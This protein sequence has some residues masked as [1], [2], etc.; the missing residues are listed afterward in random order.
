MKAVKFARYA[1][2]V[3]IACIVAAYTVYCVDSKR[4]SEITYPLV[5]ECLF[6]GHGF[7]ES[8]EHGECSVAFQLIPHVKN[9]LEIGGGAGKVSRMIN[10]RLA[11]PTR[12]V[13]VEPGSEGLG[14]HGDRSLQKNQ[15]DFKDKYT[16]VKKFAENL[17]MDDLVVLQGP[18]D[19]LFVDCEGCLE[20][21]FQTEIG[22]YTLRNARYIVN[23]MDGFVRGPEVD[24][25]L[26]HLWK[27]YG[28]VLHGIGLG[29]G[30][31]CE[32]EVW[33]KPV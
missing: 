28:F 10:Q 8:F 5:P 23:E 33:K 21:F 2:F 16:I 19:C 18:P 25:Q 11:D 27:E 15:M 14:N 22:K 31:T 9:V 1:L 7:D 4:K 13:V 32:T 29:C 12:H 24:Q 17:V 20:V 26:R 6:K 3:S 30:I